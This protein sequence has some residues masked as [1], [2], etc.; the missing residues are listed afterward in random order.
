MAI[1]TRDEIMEA[2]R[3]RVGED[4]SDEAL[5]FIEDVS[6]TISDMETRSANSRE[7]EKKYHENDES[8][9]KK[10]KERFYRPV[11]MQEQDPEPDEPAKKCLTYNDLFK[12]EC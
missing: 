9:R 7:W 10:Y 5:A 6:D 4:T 3:A 11:N 8:W 1:K 12:E 2:I